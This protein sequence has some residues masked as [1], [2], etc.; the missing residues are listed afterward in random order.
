MAAVILTNS[1]SWCS[2]E[3]FCSCTFGGI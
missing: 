3:N 1:L 2:F